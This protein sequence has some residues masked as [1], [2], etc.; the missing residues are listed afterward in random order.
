MVNFGDISASFVLGVLTPLGAVCVLP[1][2]PAF[3]AYLSNQLSG[4]QQTLT[5]NRWQPLL[6]GIVVTFG[7]ILFMTLLGLIFTTFLRQSLTSVINIV[8]P[9]AFGILAVVG[10]LLILNFDVS[11]F[12]PKAHT[13]RFKNPYIN[14][15]TFGFFFGAIVIPCNPGF[16][17][18]FFAKTVSITAA[19]FASNILNF[20]A[21]GL[22]IA[23][24]L[25]AFSALSTTASSTII[26]FITNYRRWINL[27]AG[28]IMLGVSAYYLVFVFRVFGA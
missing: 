16:I 17:A 15:F 1:L 25:L 24:P 9:I 6:L 14:A 5:P 21:F 12:L 4:G 7:V 10:V 18:A 2:F 19:D 23:A 22:G 26:N 13:P 28:I 27:V 8:S 3:L 20:F 11:K